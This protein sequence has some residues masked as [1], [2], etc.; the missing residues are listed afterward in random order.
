MTVKNRYPLPWIDD[1]FDQIKDAKV[2]YEI[3]LKS[4]YH[5][6][7]IH[8][9]NIH[10]TTFHTRYGHYEFTVVPFSL[11]NAPSVFMSLMNGPKKWQQL[12]GKRAVFDSESVNFFYFLKEKKRKEDIEEADGAVVHNG[13]LEEEVTP[14]TIEGEIE[15]VDSPFSDFGQQMHAEV[16]SEKQRVEEET[17]M[18]KVL[19]DEQGLETNVAEEHGLYPDD[20]VVEQIR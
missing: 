2:F 14:S 19:E 7:R 11:T 12:T 15:E 6:L 1:L 8:E 13:S 17:Y 5:Q 20:G 4:G 3:D 9:A 18:A 10:F 16:E